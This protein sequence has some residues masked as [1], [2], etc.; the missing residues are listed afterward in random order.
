MVSVLSA[1]HALSQ[2]GTNKLRDAA[3]YWRSAGHA[4][5]HYDNSH[6]LLSGCVDEA[7]VCVEKADLWFVHHVRTCPPD[8]C[9]FL[10]GSFALKKSTEAV[11]N[12]I[13][14]TQKNEVM[15]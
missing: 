10:G 14:I 15:L 1:H 7:E 4:L 6:F 5:L 9:L 3:I 12:G 8:G 13:P 2:A 11:R